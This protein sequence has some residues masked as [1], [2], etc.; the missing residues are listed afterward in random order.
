[1][2]FL[3][4][5]V[6]VP[7]KASFKPQKNFNLPNLNSL[8]ASFTGRWTSSLISLTSCSNIFLPHES[9]LL[10]IKISDFPTL[11]RMLVCL[12]T[13]GKS[14]LLYCVKIT[15]V[16]EGMWRALLPVRNSKAN[17]QVLWTFMTFLKRVRL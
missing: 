17:F 1:M 8:N 15:F 7:F 5:Q 14:F 13:Y 9:I 10:E 3:K 11:Q 16:Y 12:E 6:S 2:K 4:F